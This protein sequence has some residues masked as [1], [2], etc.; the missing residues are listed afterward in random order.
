MHKVDGKKI[1]SGT[2]EWAD[3]NINLIDGCAHNCRYCYAKKM[4]VRF[5]RK[6]EATWGTMRIRE[7]DVNKAYRK[8]KGRIMFPT[9]HDIVPEEPFFKACM[10]VLEKLLRA[11]NSVLVTTKPHLQVVRYICEHFK[12]FMDKI[13][14]RFTITSMDDTKLA[15]W[16]P[17]APNFQERLESLKYAS[18]A[19]FKTSISIE[20]CLDEDPRKL[21]EI[22]KPYVTESIW[23]GCMNYS[24]KYPFNSTETLKKWVQWFEKEELMRFKDSIKRRL[25]S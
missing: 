4:A 13:Q 8:K 25:R 6:T 15:D 9:S 23:L 21:V 12:K 20:P 1:T 19:G 7:R 14:F 11:D 16:E 10:T 2:K 3:F 17:G 5:G 22:L 24:G 18:Q